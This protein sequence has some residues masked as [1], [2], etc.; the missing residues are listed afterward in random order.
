MYNNRFLRLDSNITNKRLLM[1]NLNND[2]VSTEV[3]L[4]RDVPGDEAFFAH[5]NMFD[6]SEEDLITGN[7]DVDVDE[8]G[9]FV[10]SS[11]DE[12]ERYLDE[13]PDFNAALNGHADF[14]F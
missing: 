13:H 3:D 8:D 9:P 14:I 5:N 7:F 12:F 11:D 2:F 4:D 1:T 6:P 10:T